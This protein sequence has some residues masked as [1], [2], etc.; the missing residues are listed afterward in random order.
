MQFSYIISPD[1]CHF[2]QFLW[3]LHSKVANIQKIKFGMRRQ[4]HRDR[5][6]V[7]VEWVGN[8]DGVSPSP[9]DYGVCGSIVS[10]PAGSRAEPQLKTN[11]GHIKH[12]RTPVAEGK[13]GI[14]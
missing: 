5:D 3:S 6:I 8:G 13:S 10:S 12:C 7:G 11:L 2:L 9:A 4:R 14:S 1:F